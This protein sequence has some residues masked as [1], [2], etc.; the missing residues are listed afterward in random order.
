MPGFGS[1]RLARPARSLP[2]AFA[3]ALVLLVGVVGTAWAITGPTR[4]SDPAVSERT[5]TGPVPITFSVTYRNREGSAPDHVWLVV[6]GASFPMT[7]TAGDTNWHDGVRY[8]TTR[9]LPVGRHAI[10]FAAADTRKFSDAIDGGSVTVLAPPPSEGTGGSDGG[11]GPT[12]TPGPTRVPAPTSTPG[13]APRPTASPKPG[14]GA[15]GAT[16]P[17][18]PTSRPSPNPGGGSTSTGPMPVGGPGPGGSTPGGSIGP[19]GRTRP[20]GNTPDLTG[21]SHGPGGVVGQPGQAGGGVTAQGQAGVGATP[22]GSG[23]STTS[24]G[25]T[26]G[27]EPATAGPL[28][29]L[30]G[31]GLVTPEMRLA[32]SVVTTGGAVSVAM[33]FMFFGKR[34]RD[35]QPN[36]PEEVL[37]ASSARGGEPAA[38]GGLVPERSTPVPTPPVD[39]EML[40]PRWRRPS[41]L[42]ARKAD[43]LRTATTVVNL[44]FETGAVGPVE[45]R[46]RRRIRYRVVRLLDAPDELRASGIG[47]LDEGDEVQLLESSG[48]YWSVLCPDG[49]QGWL[50]R[51]VLGDVVDDAAGQDAGPDEPGFDDDVLR[52]YRSARLRAG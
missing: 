37:H 26:L 31:G 3:A 30:L 45:G 8:K 10:S 23:G 35:G 41:L 34:R 27:S 48:S 7:G 51:M 22:P 9:T 49:R 17:N 36:E 33:A 15:T 4:L 18:P 19:S 24:S 13:S 28:G 29:V 44:S 14:T 47:F 52:A 43:P 50:H 21:G 40:M 46:E 32:V 16:N 20:D 25:P 38:R 6:D 5:V 1:T 12:A 2:A 39:A 11:S 42:E